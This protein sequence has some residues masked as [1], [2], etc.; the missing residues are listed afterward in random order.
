MHMRIVFRYLYIM[1]HYQNY[2]HKCIIY[3]KD[4][5]HKVKKIYNSS[6]IIKLIKINI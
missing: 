6:Y 2:I 5:T 4:K 3:V 1:S